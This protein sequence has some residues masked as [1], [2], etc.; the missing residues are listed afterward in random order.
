MTGINYMRKKLQVDQLAATLPTVDSG[1]DANRLYS[2]E[3]YGLLDE[4]SDLVSMYIGEKEW[5][6]M[7][8]NA[9]DRTI[10]Y[11][12]RDRLAA[13][14]L[15]RVRNT[16]SDFYQWLVGSRVTAGLNARGAAK[17]NVTFDI[18]SRYA[19]VYKGGL[20]VEFTDELRDSMTI[21][22]MSEIMGQVVD[23]FDELETNII[24]RAL[25]N[26]VANGSSF[27]G[28]KYNSHVFDASQAG[29]LNSRLDFDKMLDM[30]FVMDD[31]KFNATD[32]SM[33]LGLYYDLLS[34]DEF[35][36]A[37]GNWQVTSNSKALKII[38]GATPGKPLLPGMDVIRLSVS[39]LHL[40]GQV[41]MYDKEAY[42]DFAV[43]QELSSEVAP[44]DGLHDMSMVTYRNR[45][46]LAARNPEAAVKMTNL[47]EISLSNKFAP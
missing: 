28:I 34:L 30:H 43:R 29:Y 27:T 39:P 35:R 16:D 8:K 14:D 11:Y 6:V 44:H 40:P 31:E 42:M 37:S 9:F 38:E 21:D 41:V 26:G 1:V 10:R 36:E 25:S 32:M 4:V 3:A 5:G 45:F 13:R 23:A 22:L 20:A 47:D 18:S 12:Q 15:I 19:K 7:V 46:G 2:K 33:S 24:L 17:R